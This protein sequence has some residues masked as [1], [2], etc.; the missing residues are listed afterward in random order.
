VNPIVVK[1]LAPALRSDYLRFFDHRQGPAFADNPEWAKCY[2]HFYEVPLAIEWPSLTAD[3]NRVAM[4]SRIDV[5]EMEGFLAY[6]GDAVVGWLNAQPRHRLPHCFERL[7]IEPPAIPCAPSEAAVIVCFVVA[8]AHRRRGVAR[9]LLSEALQALAARGFRLV[10]AF[11]FKTGDSK[12]AAD[13]YHGPKSLFV[14]EGFS[15]LHEVES[16]TVM[17]KILT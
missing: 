8:P 13:H 4:Q 12:N 7:R 5:A 15:V 1:S 2:C 16:M 11:P 17:R 10:D 3:D 9:V 14:A 6:D